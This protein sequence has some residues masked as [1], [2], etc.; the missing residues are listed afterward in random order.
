MQQTAPYPEALDRLVKCLRYRRDLGWRVW[1]EDDLQR[2]KPG[3]HSGESRGLTLVV[4]RCGRD[5]YHPERVLPVNHY[6]PVPPATYNEASWTRWLFDRLG[7]VDTHERME[8]FAFMNAAVPTVESEGWE[9]LNRPYAPCHGPGWDP[10]LVTVE[11][12][13]ID[14]R[15][16]FRGELNPE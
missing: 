5:T 2:D 9:S 8:D 1:L 14:R 12:T 11:R 7:D 13:D 16:S 15:T 3:R 4:Q 6:F 10:Y